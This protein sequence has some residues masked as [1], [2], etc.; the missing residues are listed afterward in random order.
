MASFSP[1]GSRIAYNRIARED[2][3]WK[4]YHGGMA[5][6]VWIYDF[7]TREDRRIT[8][9]TGTDRLPMW[10][11]DAIFF[12]SDRDGSL[13]IY[14]YDLAAGDDLA[15]DPSHRLRRPPPELRR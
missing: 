1:D 7:T 6:D 15:G 11:G 4:R 12:A 8:D 13:N 3:T 2:R 14:V 5:Q 10:I 9:Y